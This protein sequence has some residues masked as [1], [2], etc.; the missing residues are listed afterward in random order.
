MQV[1]T[2][3][4]GT[5]NSGTDVN[6]GTGDRWVQTKNK[7]IGTC[8]AGRADADSCNANKEQKTQAEATI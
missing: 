8:E 3:N 6:T 4:K 7:G 2:K 5:D 1:Q